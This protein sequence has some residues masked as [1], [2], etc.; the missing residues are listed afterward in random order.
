MGSGLAVAA[1][2]TFRG[3]WHGCQLG[4]YELLCLRS[5]VTHGHEI[6]VFTYDQEIVVPSWVRRRDA[7]EI[8]PTDHV[9]RYRTGWWGNGSPSLHS[10]LFR[11]AL[12]NQLGG[13]W[14]DLDMLLLRADVPDGEYFYAKS[15]RDI[16]WAGALKF[17]AGHPLC[18]EAIE[19]IGGVSEENAQW[20]ET[21]PRL[22]TEL[23]A[24]YGMTAGARQ[25]SDAYP[26]DYHEIAAI[27]DPKR[28]AEAR[29]RCAGSSFLHLYNELCCS[30]GLPRDL[31]PPIDSFLDRMF[32]E[33]DLGIS[34]SHRMTFP[35]I[36]RWIGNF[37]GHV[38]YE[39]EYKRLKAE[40][41]ELKRTGDRLSRG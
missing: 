31:G 19:R 15:F 2:Q 6:E 35:Q 23:L 13:W 40:N 4:P 39:A 32:I 24:K 12:L 17:P 18:I 22:L 26:Y 5:F 34:F 11:L 36:D 38:H 3:F 8:L 1:K 29:E 10:N 14:V 27:F 16:I 41:E 37:L 28:C 33:H 20:G 30:S 25:T 21:G 7:R 9:M